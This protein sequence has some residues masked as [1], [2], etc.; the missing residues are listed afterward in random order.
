M[1]T[2]EKNTSLRGGGE[3]CGQISRAARSELPRGRGVYPAAAERERGVVGR[4][5]AEARTRKGVS[6]KELQRLLLARGLE[7]SYA[8]I[9][10]WEQ[11][12]AVP[13]AYQLLA[14]C[15]ALDIPDS[16][17]Y[18]MESCAEL[19]E[20][21]LQKAADY[22][23]DL[24]ASGRYRPVP[25]SPAPAVKFIEMPVSTLAASAGPGEFLDDE[26]IELMR[27]PE[28]SVPAG[29]DYALRVSG[30][31]MEPVYQDRQLVW[32]QNCNS[33]RPGEVGI[34]VLDGVGFIK[35]YAEQRPDA[36][37]LDE[38]TDSSG[39]V[40]NKPVLISYNDKYAPRVVH[41]GARFKICGRVLR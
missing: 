5:I 41:S 22:R 15:D 32:V 11:N 2:N 23:A 8:T 30:D 33:L 26:N 29:A 7:V 38:Y 18:F 17:T 35:A 12:E 34:F 4:R 24:I 9:V 13:N 37:E 27:F 36:D 1:K 31:S 14:V 19:N 16:Y 21:G 39:V 10:R 20:A 3:A 6:M 40:H 25:L 28:S